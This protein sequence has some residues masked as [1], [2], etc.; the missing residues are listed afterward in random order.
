ML[1]EKEILATSVSVLQH[2]G[3]YSGPP[4]LKK[5]VFLA[6]YELAIN[7]IENAVRKVDNF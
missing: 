3:W 5:T 7:G 4:D 6:S 2:D 1:L